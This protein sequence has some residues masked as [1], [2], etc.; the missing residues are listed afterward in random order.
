ML[1]VHMEA[2]FTKKAT[3]KIT[4][5]CEDGRRIQG[6]V[7]TAKV[8]GEPTTI[9]ATSIGLNE[10]GEQVAEFRYTWS[11]KAKSKLLG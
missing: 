8:T 11:L 3:G 6:A 4:F 7:E 5:M 1:V 2:D 9:Q 10:Q